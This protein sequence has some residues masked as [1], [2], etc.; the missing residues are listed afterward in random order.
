[1]LEG[2][3]VLEVGGFISAPYCTMLL[4]DLGAEVIKIENPDGGDPFRQWGHSK[5]NDNPNFRAFNRNKRSLAL[6]LSSHEGIDTFRKLAARADVIVENLRPGKMSS[7]G[8]G[9]NEISAVN[10]KIVYCSISCFGSNNLYSTKPGFD[11]LAQSMSGLLSL[12]SPSPVPQPLGPPL[13]DILVG[14]F[15]AY[16]ILGGLI[17]RNLKGKPIFLE[18]SMLASCIQVCGL[19]FQHFFWSHEEQSPDSRPKLSQAYGFEGIDGKSFVIHLSS[20]PK[21]WEALLQV[22]GLQN[23]EAD[24]RFSSYANR[25]QH[26]HEIKEILGPIFATKPRAFWLEKLEERD[27]PCGPLYHISEVFD[28]KVIGNLDLIKIEDGS[29][30]ILG[31]VDFEGKQKV[32]KRPPRLGEDTEAI[33]RELD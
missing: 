20:L 11:T 28:D 3:R 31:P 30:Y 1:M 33:L 23:L 2:I 17:E 8:L 5:D 21:F 13:A 29:P 6:D 22:V 7:M 12:L 25:I 18:T 14:I 26:Y 27:V 4:S 19:F 24:E 9:F 32:A 16:G 10:D 15:G